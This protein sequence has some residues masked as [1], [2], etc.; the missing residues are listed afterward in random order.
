MRRIPIEDLEVPD[1]WKDEAA[2]AL[3]AV[4][5]YENAERKDRNAEIERHATKT[6]RALKDALMDLSQDKCWYCEIR[7]DRSLGAVDHYRPKGKV[8][9]VPDHPGYWWLAFDEG[10]YRFTC[11]LCNSATTDK[12]A[13]TVGGKRELFPLFDEDKRAKTK[14]QS[15]EHEEPKLLDPTVAAD[16]IL[17]TWMVDGNAAPRYAASQNAVWHERADVSMKVYHLNH[18]KLR[19]RRIKICNEL[20][21]LIQEGDILYEKAVTNQPYEKESMKRVTSQIMEILSENAELTATAKQYIREYR[22]GDTKR[23]WLEGVISAA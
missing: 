7:Q 1:G 2:K 18:Y 12:K 14:D 17:L 11:T 21:L 5:A 20:K 8:D 4:T 19:R 22:T 15:Y 6:W 9:G 3:A 23:E 16:A 10:N 13:G